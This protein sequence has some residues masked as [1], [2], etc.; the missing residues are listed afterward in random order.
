MKLINRKC[1]NIVLNKF[2]ELKLLLLN[3]LGMIPR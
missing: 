2:K 1:E 3:Y